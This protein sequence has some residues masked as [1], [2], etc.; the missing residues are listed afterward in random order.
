MFYQPKATRT[1]ARQ[2]TDH[3][4]DHKLTTDRQQTDNKPST[5][6]PQT[7][8][9]PYTNRGWGS[10][11][12]PQLHQAFTDRKMR[13]GGRAAGKRGRICRF[14]VAWGWGGW[15][16]LRQSFMYDL[17]WVCGLKEPFGDPPGGPRRIPWGIGRGDPQVY[18]DPFPPMESHRCPQT[19]GKSW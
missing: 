10:A 5:S 3:K 6:R 15:A 13:L 11:H 9:K 4:T 2:Q 1:T 14:G 8:H 7:H 18:G 17:W 12:Q 16:R 19:H